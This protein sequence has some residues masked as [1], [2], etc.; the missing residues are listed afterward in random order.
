MNFCE[1]GCG[2]ATTVH[3]GKPRRFISG[4]NARA[5]R[6]IVPPPNPSGICECGCGQR[7]PLARATNQERGWA[8]G[9]HIRFVSGHNSN[10]PERQ[11]A[12]AAVNWKGDEASYEAIH[13]WLSGHFPKSGTCEECGEVTGKTQ[14]AFRRHPEPYTRNRDDYREL[15]PSCHKLFDIDLFSFDLTHRGRLSST[16]PQKGPRARFRSPRAVATPGS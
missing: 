14:H 1:C 9:E 8:K 3:R 5:V 10:M 7:T 13:M 15:C 6:V 11:M 12:I 16:S 2:Q 4:H